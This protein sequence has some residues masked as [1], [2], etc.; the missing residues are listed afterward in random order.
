MESK[1]EV[2]ST[3]LIPGPLNHP[4]PTTM[5]RPCYYSNLNVRGLQRGG[6]PD[7]VSHTTAR[8]S[9]F[10]YLKDTFTVQFH[11]TSD[12]RGFTGSACQSLVNAWFGTNTPVQTPENIDCIWQNRDIATHTW[13]AIRIYLV[14]L[15][16]TRNFIKQ[17][18]LHSYSC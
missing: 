8:V 2:H 18:S 10:F 13:K 16:R 1:G 14:N 4:I 6:E 7:L 12:Y 11:A 17:S 15:A 3:G 9:P 5:G